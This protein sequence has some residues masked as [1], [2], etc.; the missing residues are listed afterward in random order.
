MKAKKKKKI[1]QSGSD[2]DPEI[3]SEEW[4]LSSMKSTLQAE[5]YGTG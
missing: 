5:E 4:K 2:S 3:Q 1:N